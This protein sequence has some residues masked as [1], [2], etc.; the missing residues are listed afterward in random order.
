[1]E[2]TR[3]QYQTLILICE[4][5]IKYSRTNKQK[6]IK[7]ELREKNYIEKAKKGD[8]IYYCWWG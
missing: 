2:S 3:I 1:M 5:F 8:K 4:K 6:L 7:R